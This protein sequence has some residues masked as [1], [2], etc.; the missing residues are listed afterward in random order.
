MNANQLQSQKTGQDQI[1]SL[2]RAELAARKEQNA[3]YSLRSFAKRL[4]LSPGNLSGILNGRLSVTRKTAEKAFRVIPV[5]PATRDE[6]LAGLTNRNAVSA[7]SSQ[8]VR[9]LKEDEVSLISDWYFVAV[10]ALSEV[11]GFQGSPAWI[12][13]RF[14]IERAQARDALKRLE[15][16]GLLMRNSQGE[17]VYANKPIRTTT[18][19]PS[20]AIRKHHVDGLGLARR[21]MSEDEF[22]S[23][24]F[25]G[26]T[27][28]VSARKLPQAKALIRQ[29]QR[30]LS[31]LMDVG[32]GNT[33]VYRVN[34]QLFALSDRRTQ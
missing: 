32:D 12:A 2:L 16:L 27:M 1:V 3:S 19:I 14:G 15:R 23:C 22:T 33:Q 24:D 11:P 5:E 10:L 21:A 25:T 8:A 7:L 28:A 18:D 29:F 20:A 4:G 9:L 34:V 17:L 26:T 6:L 31:K 30:R 13:D